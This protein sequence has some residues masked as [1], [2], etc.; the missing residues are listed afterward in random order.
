MTRIIESAQRAGLRYAIATDHFRMDARDA[1][2][3]GYH[4]GMLLIVGEEISPRYNHLLALNLKTPIVVWKSETNAQRM[5]NEVNS[6]GG[7]AFIAHPDH[8]GAPLV[9]SRAFPWLAWD[10]EGY[11]GLGIWDLLSDWSSQLKGVWST[12]RACLQ[13]GEALQGPRRKTLERWDQ[14]TQEK[15]IVAI[16]ESDNHGHHRRYFGFSR[17]IF[18]F[19]FAFRT[20]RTHVLLKEALSGN[21]AQDQVAILQALRD[22]SSYVSLDLWKDPAGFMFRAYNDTEETHAGGTLLRQGP[23]LLETKL[24]SAGRLRLIRDGR[25]VKEER[26]RGHLQW[27]LDVPGVY[28]VEADQRVSGRWRPWIFSN[29]IWVR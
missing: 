17:Q 9:G 28:R 25:I 2:F 10:A 12:L 4:N 26:R 1:G 18:S 5:I 29:P 22:G 7:Y 3:E 24:P 16:G 20:I 27:D 11:A 13:P 23:S 19:D 21:A 6:Q 8:E 15:H 14:L